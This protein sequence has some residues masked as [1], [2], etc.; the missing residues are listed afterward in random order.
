LSVDER[1]VLRRL[2]SVVAQDPTAASTY[3]GTLITLPVAEFAAHAGLTF[4][5]ARRRLNV[6]AH[7]LF[8]RGVSVKSVDTEVHF[9]WADMVSATDEFCEL[10]F[11]GLFIKFL[12]LT[13]NA[14]AVT[15]PL[16]SFSHAVTA[17]AVV[18]RGTKIPGAL[19][20]VLVSRLK[21]RAK[22]RKAM[23]WE[24]LTERVGKRLK[25]IM[26]GAR[27]MDVIWAAHYHVPWSILRGKKYHDFTHRDIDRMYAWIIANMDQ[28]DFSK[29]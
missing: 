13:G 11:S 20:I 16:L 14:A 1:Y 4:K 12:L 21:A 23:N 6:A 9:N 24:Q 15:V 10:Q 26:P 29:E 8:G 5:V 19:S 18:A 28:P 2:A 7:A 3:C 25:K 17:P 22:R 27:V